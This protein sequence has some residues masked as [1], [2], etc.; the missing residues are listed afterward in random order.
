MQHL[1]LKFFTFPEIRKHNFFV[2]I[3]VRFRENIPVDE[4]VWF[5]EN[6]YMKCKLNFTIRLFFDELSKK[7]L[8]KILISLSWLFQEVVHLQHTGKFFAEIFHQKRN[9]K[10]EFADSQTKERL[11][12]FSLFLCWFCSDFD[13]IWSGMFFG[14]QLA[15]ISGF[16]WG[17]R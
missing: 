1:F 5:L 15:G 17:Y 6:A 16:V 12:S 10:A 13:R 4:L 7:Q 8:L 11:L 2:M 9:P 3:V 14:Q